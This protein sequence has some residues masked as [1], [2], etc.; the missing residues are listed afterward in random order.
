[1]ID[2]TAIRTAY[3]V[4][5]L[6][7]ISAASEELGIHRASVVRHIDAVEEQLGQKLFIRGQTGYKP[8]EMGFELIDMVGV[9]EFQ[10][11][12][13]V[14]KAQNQTKELTG[15]LVISS[16]EFRHSL[17]LP[18]VERFQS[19]HPGVRIQ[20][21]SGEIQ[22]LE[23]KNHPDYVVQEMIYGEIRL[24]ANKKYIEK[25]GLPK[26]KGDLKNHRFFKPPK[27]V[28]RPDFGVW[29]ENIVPEE[30]FYLIA[31]SF[32]LSERAIL[33]GLVMGFVPTLVA[34]QQENLVPV[35][36]ELPPWRY[37]FYV[38]THRDIHHTPKIQTFLKILK[39]YY[40]SA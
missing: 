23:A 25:F 5:K 9:A 27:S 4:A 29:L 24:Y 21:I 1:M 8:T 13:L 36:P 34:K 15:E 11:N 14:D 20:L 16:D 7:T 35:L 18:V 38:M 2:W 12:M 31:N 19:S 33:E 32:E 3:K 37:S 10:L 39:R 40:E 6:G 17:I 22:A 30:R 28:V 26:T